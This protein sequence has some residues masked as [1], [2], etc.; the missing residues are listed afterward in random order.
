MF[1][2][3]ISLRALL[4]SSFLALGLILVL[5]YSLVS[6]E[7][8]IRGLDA[9]MATNMEKTARTFSEVIGPGQ[10]ERAREFSGFDVAMQWASLP[11]YALE[12][13]PGG[14]GEPGQ[15][16]K[17]EGSSW[18]SRPSFVIF[19]MR[20]ET[21]SG[22]LYL[23]QKLTPPATSELLPQAA[24]QNRLL[25]L[26]VSILVIGFILTVGWLL[27]RHV[28]RPMA[29]LRAW[30]H[31][32]NNDKLSQPVPDFSYPELN[33][34]AELIRNS[35]STVEQALD[36]ERRFLKHASHELR[37]PISTIRSNIELQRKLTQKREKY[38]DEKSIVDRIDRASLTMKHLTETLLWLNHEP[39]TPLQ[40]EAVDLPGLIRELAGEMSYLLAGKPVTTEIS[41]SSYSCTVPLVPA[42]I[43]LGNLIRNA[44]QH[45]WEGTVVI[46]QQEGRV[47]ISNPVEPDAQNLSPASSENTGYGLGLELTT[48]LSQRIGWHYTAKREGNYHRVV[49]ETESSRDS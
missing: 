19:A 49:V 39:D 8:F 25:T 14:P 27:L 23:S 47:T 41:T 43:I 4:I 3:R 15:L 28:S 1:K 5:A 30:T 13:F 21:A 11:A 45:C 32:L 42:R 17:K 9:A 38:E 10:R 34:M 7:H 36:R 48:T 46:D 40:S 31:S 33:E 20:Y 12:A 2:A 26:T 44:Y 16:L 22:P 35:L 24:R 29:A 18:F 37:T 6:K